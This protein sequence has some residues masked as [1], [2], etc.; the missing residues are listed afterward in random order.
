MIQ[1]QFSGRVRMKIDTTENWQKA[2]DFI[3]L[4]GE[5]IV[6]SDYATKEVDGQIINI[7]NYKVGDGLA[8]G[9]DLPFVN[10]DLR[11]AFSAH[12]FNTDVHVTPAEKDFWN[13]KVRCYIETVEDDEGYLVDGENLIFTTN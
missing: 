7:P 6:Y 5:I 3:P 10:D 9:I 11:D 4:K 1:T 12:V 8:Y 13:N 2:V